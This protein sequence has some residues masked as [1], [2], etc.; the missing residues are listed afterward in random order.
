LKKEIEREISLVKYT[1]YESSNLEK[2]IDEYR[3]SLSQGIGGLFGTVGT[4]IVSGFNYVANHIGLS[5]STTFMFEGQVLSNGLYQKTTSLDLFGGSID[6]SIGYQPTPQELVSEISIGWSEH[7]SAGFY[8]TEFDAQGVCQAGGIA[9]H[10][11]LG[12]GS[13]VGISSTYPDPNRPRTSLGH[14]DLSYE[15]N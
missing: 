7:L 4:G 5:M 3:T 6:L 12:L 11:G 1:G 15:Q 13:P 10:A 2:L 8:C 14:L 9:I